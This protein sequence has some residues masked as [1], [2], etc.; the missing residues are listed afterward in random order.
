MTTCRYECH[1]GL[2]YCRVIDI[3]KGFLQDN[4][5]KEVM[6]AFGYRL[7]ANT[8]FTKKMAVRS[9]LFSMTFLPSFLKINNK[10]WNCSI[11]P[12]GTRPLFIQTCQTC[13]G[14]KI[15]HFLQ[16]H[17][18]ASAPPPSR[19]TDGDDKNYSSSKE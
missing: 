7:A 18:F 17:L 16:R 4:L 1:D 11:A 8:S 14:V 6:R 15:T 10:L 19:N 3:L 5:R 12:I 13:Q 9:T 2:L